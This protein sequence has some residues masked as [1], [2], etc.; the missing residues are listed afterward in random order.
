MS[1]AAEL[2]GA[3]PATETERGL[4]G[5]GAAILVAGLAVDLEMLKGSGCF[6]GAETAPMGAEKGAGVAVAQLQAAAEGGHTHEKL[7][8]ELLFTSIDINSD[9]GCTP[10]FELISYNRTRRA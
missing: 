5:G 1:A 9:N 8:V 6:S 2:P 7:I 10:N 4:T 3:A